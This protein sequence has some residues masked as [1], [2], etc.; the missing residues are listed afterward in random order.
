MS[1][2]PAAGGP[3]P[4]EARLSG[5]AAA[6]QVRSPRVSDHARFSLRKGHRNLSGVISDAVCLR[7]V[8][9]APQRSACPG[10]S[11]PSFVTGGRA[12][13]PPAR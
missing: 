8:E 9:H 4:P 3:D 1:A 12:A 13:P 11:T 2:G 6:F 7:L 10:E 5:P